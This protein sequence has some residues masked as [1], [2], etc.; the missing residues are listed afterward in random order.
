MSYFYC[1][2][3][4]LKRALIEHGFTYICTGVNFHSGTKFWL[5][6][7]SDALNTYKNEVYPNE[8]DKY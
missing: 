6:E 1:Y 3:P 7:S 4:R 5:F 2:S 8:R